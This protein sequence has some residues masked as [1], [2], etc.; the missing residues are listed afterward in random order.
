[1]KDL[2]IGTRLGLAFG[3]LLFLMGVIALTAIHRVGIVSDSLKQSSE[4]N[5]VKQRYAINFR[6]SVHDRAISLR[7]VTLAATAADAQK[8]IEDI[9]LLANNYT[10]SAGP[11]DQMFAQSPDISAEEKAALGVCAAEPGSS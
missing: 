2:S 8:H 10:K 11:L 4:V 7:D 6:G 9:K 1:M 5:S 3:S